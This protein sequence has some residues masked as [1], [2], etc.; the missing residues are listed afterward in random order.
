MIWCICSFQRNKVRLRGF[1]L[2][3]WRKMCQSVG[4]VLY[5]PMLIGDEK[6][7]YWQVRKEWVGHESLQTCK[8]C[9]GNLQWGDDWVPQ[10]GAMG[11]SSLLR[12]DIH[13][14]EGRSYL[15]R[16]IWRPCH[17]D[18]TSIKVTQICHLLETGLKRPP[19]KADVIGLWLAV[20]KTYAIWRR[21]TRPPWLDFTVL[22][23]RKKIANSGLVSVKSFKT[24]SKE[25]TPPVPPAVVS[26]RLP[27]SVTES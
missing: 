22:H 3:G 19:R 2:H 1:I 17:L 7:A 12:S 27:L 26:S 20:S 9:D 16:V 24:P 10:R 5:R 14:P 8:A 18:F 11:D 21:S 4:I 13:P 25:Q 15:F 23:L 6:F